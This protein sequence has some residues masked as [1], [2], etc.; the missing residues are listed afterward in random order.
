M[1]QQGPPDAASMIANHG[2]GP[3]KSGRFHFSGWADPL[4]SVQFAVRARLTGS[5]SG[6]VV[7]GVR[8]VLRS[9]CTPADY[10]PVDDGREPRFANQMRYRYHCI[11]LVTAVTGTG[12]GSSA[13]KSTSL[14]DYANDKLDAGVDDAAN[15]PDQ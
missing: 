1:R 12:C 7:A 9:P 15:I 13:G 8:L 6:L 10:R 5:S 3:P 2:S 14:K 4:G 11:L